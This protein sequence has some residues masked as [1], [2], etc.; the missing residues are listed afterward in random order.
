MTPIIGHTSQQQTLKK[1]VEQDK[2]P[3]AMLLHGPQGIGKRLVAERI[4]Q[5]LLCPASDSSQEPLPI[6]THADIYAQIQ[7]GSCPDYH[8]LQPEEGKASIK[9][10]HVRKL[11]E[12]L[13]L[14]ADVRRVIIVDAAENLT[15]EAANALLKTLEEPG[16]LIHFFL[17]SHQL[18]QL[19]PTLISRCRQ[20]AF[21]PLEAK[22]TID[23]LSPLLPETTPDKLEI[24]ATLS[25]GCPGIAY[26]WGE[27]AFSIQ[28]TLEEAWQD[29]ILIPTKVEALQQQKHVPLALTLLTQQVAQ[30]AKQ[31]AN[32]PAAEVYQALQRLQADRLELNLTPAAVLEHSLR[33]VAHQLRKH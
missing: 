5:Y 16:A 32:A 23:V 33:Q 20:L 11:L 14:T 29:P 2:F 24:L 10:E 18:S 17:I 30:L 22:D 26:A 1:L 8:I 21:S 9:I 25:Q 31:Q 13:S 7:A 12:N 6:D 3:H 28:T 19:L 15:T 27:A 4:G